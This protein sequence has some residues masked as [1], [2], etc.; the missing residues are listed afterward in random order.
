[1][2]THVKVLGI[3]HIVFGGLGLLA[4]IIVLAVFGGLAGLISGSGEG[5]ALAA[6][7]LV[8]GLGGII[9][10]ILLVLSLP[11]LIV[12]I[13]LLEFRS[14]ARVAGIVLSAINLL[15]IPFGTALGIYGLW[16]LLNRDTEQLFARPQMAGI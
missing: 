9:S 3:I 13:G 1:M 6:I 14:W 10:V 11:G 5:G 12:G 2:A 4:G 16:V 15:H 8:G 7:P